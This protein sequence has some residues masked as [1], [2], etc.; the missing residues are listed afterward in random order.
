[1]RYRSSLLSSPLNM[2]FPPPASLDWCLSFTACYL[3]GFLFRGLEVRSTSIRLYLPRASPP[4][5][6]VC[7]LPPYGPCPRMCITPH[8]ST[9]ELHTPPLPQIFYSISSLLTLLQIA[10]FG[11]SNFLELNLNLEQN[12]FLLGFCLATLGDT[13]T[14]VYI[15]LSLSGFPQKLD[16][17]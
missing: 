11:P 14:I 2:M 16:M 6:L 15:H 17:S 7:S 12:L 9:S 5:S 3:F 8:L 10:L 4:S 13:S 1:M